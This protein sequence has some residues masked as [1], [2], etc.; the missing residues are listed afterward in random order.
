MWDVLV[1]AVK[2]DDIGCGEV[3]AEAAN[4]SG[5]QEDELLAPRF[6]ILV[7]RVDAIV[8]CS[9]AINMAVFWV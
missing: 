1:A 7:D 4:A 2:D 9:P 5:E 6:V 8:V 3:K